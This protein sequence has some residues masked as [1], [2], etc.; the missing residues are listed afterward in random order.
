MIRFSLLTVLLLSSLGCGDEAPAPKEHATGPTAAKSPA[1]SQEAEAPAN[2]QAANSQGNSQTAKPAPI[3]PLTLGA[4]GGNKTQPG[5]GSSGASAGESKMDGVVEAMQPLQVF[6]GQW[7][8]TTR[9]MGAGTANWVWDFKTD[10]SQPALVMSTKDHPYFETAR[11]TFLTDKQKFQLTAKDKDKNQRTYQGEFTEEPHTVTGDTGKAEPRF[12]MMLNEIGNED[13]RKLVGVKLTL[14]EKNRLWMEVF[15][16]SGKDIRLQ[17]NVANQ[18]EGT[19]FAVSD[20]NYGDKE[21]IVSQGLGTMEVTYMGRTYYVCCSG[22]QSAFTDDP[23]FWINKALDR[24]KAEE[25]E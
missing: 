1:D 2:T 9:T 12:E 25:K 15:Q 17:D 8:T 14:R 19:S 24:K 13:A 22:C 10:K 3:K 23:T 21:C 6:L 4:L 16:K 7:N 11:L 20:T 18:R 5:N